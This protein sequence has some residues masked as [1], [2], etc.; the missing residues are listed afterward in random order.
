M[1]QRVKTNIGKVVASPQRDMC[2]LC[3]CHANEITQQRDTSNTIA[4]T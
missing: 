3:H 4:E 2:Q 1:R